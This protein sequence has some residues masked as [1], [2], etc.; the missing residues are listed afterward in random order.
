MAS[1]KII[2]SK[3]IFHFTPPV[4]WMNDPNG[5]VFYKGV[6]HLFYQ[7]NPYQTSWGDIHWGHATSRDLLRWEDQRIALIPQADII[8]AFSGCGLIDVDN[9]TKF[10]EYDSGLVF[11]FTGVTLTENHS[12]IEHQYIGYLDKNINKII[13]PCA[14][15][16]IENPG[17]S[18][19]RD[20]KVVFSPEDN[21]WKMVLACGDHIRIYSS[22]NLIEWDEQCKFYPEELNNNEIIEC[23]NLILLRL[24]GRQVWVLIM[25]VLDEVSRNSSTFYITGEF[26][27]TE[28]VSNFAMRPLD[29]GHDFY[30]PQVWFFSESENDMNPIVIGWMNNWIYAEDFPCSSWNGILSIPREISLKE[31]SG[32]LLLKQNPKIPYS[33][34]CCERLVIYP[35]EGSS[36]ITFDLNPAFY[37][38]EMEFSLRGLNK[39]KITLSEKNRKAFT[40]E[41]D[42]KKDIICLDRSEVSY[43]PMAERGMVKKEIPINLR[44]ELFNFIFILDLWT[45]EFFINEGEVVIS[46]LASWSSF[47]NH[48]KFETE[49]PFKLSQPVKI[50]ELTIP[51][52]EKNK[53]KEGE[54]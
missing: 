53:E 54:G 12:R 9:C 3:P 32:T 40:I 28:F 33:E 6:Y 11:I 25:S 50:R 47:P 17:L 46:E 48:I 27:S 45:L 15:R 37:I 52:P 5:L 51:L 36:D 19:F 2:N 20:P 26:V 14:N 31:V 49:G 10:F 21:V 38:F 42:F 1:S 7:H 29:F 41:V 43:S 22:N 35:R 8:H 4:N 18:N 30:A 16:I 34:D 44:D 13:L 23:P 39:L 24:K